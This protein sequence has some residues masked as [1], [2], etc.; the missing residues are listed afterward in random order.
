MP[1]SPFGVRGR[2][3]TNVGDGRGFDDGYTRASAFIP[4][5][6]V[7]ENA[8]I[9]LDAGGFGSYNQGAGMNL[10]LGA[11]RYFTGVDQI[12]GANIWFDLDGDLDNDVSFSRVGLGVE[13]IG[14]VL[15]FRGNAYIPLNNEERIFS[16]LS[17]PGFVGNNIAITQTDVN[18]LSYGGVE[19]EVGGPL[20]YL[21]RYG[22]TSFVGM[23]G[24]RHDDGEDTLGV[25]G[26][27][28]WQL[29]DDLNIGGQ[30]THDDVFG[31]NFWVNIDLTTPRGSWFDWGRTG[32]FRN[33]SV[34]ETLDSAV[35]RQYRAI[36]LQQIE[37]R[38]ENLQNA[39]GTDIFVCHIDPNAVSGDGTAENPFNNI[40][41]LLGSDNCV[42][43]SC[44]IIRVVASG[45][46]T[47]LIADG[48]INLADNQQ[49]L[50]SA[51]R[52]FITATFRGSQGR[53]ELPGFTGGVRP[54]STSAVVRTE[55]EGAPVFGGGDALESGIE[56][57]HI[58]TGGAVHP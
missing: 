30:F 32:W 29:N 8:L 55:L 38:Q 44:V 37:E 22:A 9:F 49:L 53:F 28:N 56:A 16:N 40:N 1:D 54:V 6:V 39:D 24:L 45:S 26:R 10:G 21:G 58:L 57:L 47:T 11:R 18:L 15:S 34:Y 50:S 46:A 48:P 19:G 17:A 25:S 43:A 14:N 5:A 36:T 23:Y 3:E 2:I 4:W 41:T 12:V 13:A 33:P 42:D 31:S 20:P 51:E 7:D 27:L 35:V 52:Q